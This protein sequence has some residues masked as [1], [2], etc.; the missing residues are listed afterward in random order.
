M[1]RPSGPDRYF[2]KVKEAREALREKALA[3]LDKYEEI[4][5]KAL[6][7]GDYETAAKHTQWLIEHMPNEAGERMI[8][9][10]AAN[11]K[12]IESGPVA[13]TIQIGIALGGVQQPALPPVVEVVDVDPD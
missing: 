10:S 6:E 11:P 3:I 13:P 12:Q 4:I 1:S 8:D 2:P 5:Q 7:A 9:S